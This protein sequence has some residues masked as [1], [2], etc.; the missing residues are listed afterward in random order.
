MIA[1]SD[2]REMDNRIGAIKEAATDLQ[3][4]SLGI[5]AID[6]NVERILA[7][8]AMLE[9]NISDVASMHREERFDS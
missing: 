4:I 3:K 7:T 6:R 8:V 9:I 5:Q 2:I 1:R